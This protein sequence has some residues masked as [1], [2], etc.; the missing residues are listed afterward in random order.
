VPV[1]P[2]RPQP[3]L[4]DPWGVAHL[5]VKIREGFQLKNYS[6]SYG[7]RNWGKPTIEAANLSK[8]AAILSLVNLK[9]TFGERWKTEW[10]TRIV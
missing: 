9:G 4:G 1:I 10:K 7:E 5:V 6:Y 2:K 3:Q 8:S